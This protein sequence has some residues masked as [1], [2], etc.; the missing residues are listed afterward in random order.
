[1]GTTKLK[2]MCSPKL[3]RVVRVVPRS[4]LDVLIADTMVHIARS[5]TTRMFLHLNTVKRHVFPAATI[6]LIVSGA[7]DQQNA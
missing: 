6:W 2:L 4:F 7:K 3:C 1:M 5:A